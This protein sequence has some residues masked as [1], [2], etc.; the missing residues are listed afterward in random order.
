MADLFDLDDVR[1]MPVEDAA[2]RVIDVWREGGPGME[3]AVYELDQVLTRMRSGP[4]PNPIGLWATIREG[5]SWVKARLLDGVACPV[6]G[7]RAQLYKRTI[8][9]TMARALIVMWNEAGLDWVHLPT[10][11]GALR[12]DEAKLVHWGLIEEQPDERDDG[13][14][15]GIWRITDL[16]VRFV[17]G[18]AKVPKY[19]CIYN[20]RC[21]GHEGPD[22][23]IHECLGVKFRLDELLG[24]RP[25]GPMPQPVG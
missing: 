14:R 23:T 4:T 18:E 6:C 22:V 10:L 1:I 15:A 2:Q 24:H 13:G 20:K 11:V 25:V 19:A 7:Q 3:A 17:Q 21:F 5:A 16:G 12:A 8:T 9:S